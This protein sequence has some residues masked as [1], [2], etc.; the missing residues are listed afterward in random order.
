M[1]LR[2]LVG[3][4]HTIFISE[5]DH[6][7]GKFNRAL[8]DKILVVAEE[9]SWGGNPRENAKLR[10]MVTR[11]TL[12]LEPKGVDAFTVRACHRYI[13]TSNGDWP[14]QALARERR[15]AFLQVGE[16]RQRDGE[17]FVSM[18]EELR[19][20]GYGGLMAALLG[21]GIDEELLFNPPVTDLLREQQERSLGGIDRWINSCLMRGYFVDGGWKVQVDPDR[22]LRVY[23]GA[24]PGDR[25]STR[26]DIG[27]RL[28]ALFYPGLHT[29]GGWAPPSRR[30]SGSSSRNYVWRLPNLGRCRE[31]FDKA[32]GS[33][34]NWGEEEGED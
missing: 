34:S 22:L 9:I 14:M 4:V 27:R 26:E 2:E 33:R 30:T 16:G 13:F 1:V 11:E 10:D 29:T 3:A 21:S 19:R 7:T 25:H 28:T 24:Y 6:L 23:K 18:K 32:M 17:W 31:L 12:Q 20:G 8:G 15:F 5:S